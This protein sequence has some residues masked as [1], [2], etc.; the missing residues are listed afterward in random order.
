MLFNVHGIS[1][2]IRK[3][4][5]GRRIG[6]RRIECFGILSLCSELMSSPWRRAFYC[7]WEY[8]SVS[9]ITTKPHFRLISI[10]SPLQELS[11]SYYF[12][13]CRLS[14][15]CFASP[16]YIYS[17]NLHSRKS[18]SDN[19]KHYECFLQLKRTFVITIPGQLRQLIQVHD[20]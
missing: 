13:C 11:F 14:V 15:I 5:L 6:L 8:Q 7:C 10:F 16:F 4:I 19:A 20:L 12:P 9:F 1:K 18:N 17:C 2:F 3:L